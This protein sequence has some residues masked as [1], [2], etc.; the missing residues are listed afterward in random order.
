MRM[1]PPLLLQLLGLAGVGRVGDHG[2]A[3]P[4]QRLE[5][6]EQRGHV[7]RVGA[8]IVPVHVELNLKIAGIILG[9]A[10]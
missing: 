7:Q 10:N 1:V 3:H 6:A 8:E 5:G 9:S 4:V 2:E